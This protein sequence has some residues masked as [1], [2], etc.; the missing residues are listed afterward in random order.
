MTEE[1]P[2]PLAPVTHPDGRVYWPRKIIA[3]PVADYD[4][5]TSGVM[6]LGTHD[7]ERARV[8]ADQCAAAWVGG[9]YAAVDPVAGWYREGYESGQ[10]R[11]IRDETK[12]R[13]GVWWSEIVERTPGIADGG[14]SDRSE[15]PPDMTRRT[16]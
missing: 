14:S 7:V 6:V 1:S 13:A 12:G 9:G 10:R 2:A 16:P 4:E 5:M 11:W 8:L 3:Y 15:Y